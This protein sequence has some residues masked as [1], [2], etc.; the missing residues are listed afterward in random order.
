MSPLVPDF[1]QDFFTLFN[2]PRHFQL[3][4]VTLEQGYLALQAQVHPDKFSHLPE[5]ERRLSLQWATRVN[6]A[7]QTLRNPLNRA[8]YLLSLHGVD[9]QEESNTAMPT[10]FLMQQM[11]WRE[12]LDEAKQVQNMTVLD[13]LEQRM[14]HARRDLEQELARD[15]DERHDFASA[16]GIVRKLRFL[17][18]L[19]EEISSA[20]DELDS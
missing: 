14:Q 18:K 1:Q 11:E 16:S 8:R 17:E 12:A 9:T 5:A 6:E 13:E 7:Y 3:D 4:G 2:L 19:A 15:L 10:D 20:F